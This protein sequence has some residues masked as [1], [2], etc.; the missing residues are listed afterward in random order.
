MTKRSLAVISLFLCG[1]PGSAAAA[2]LSTPPRVPAATPPPAAAPYYNWSGF[3]AG[4]NVG[5]GWSN[6]DF[7]NA[8]SAIGTPG[9][10][11]SASVA[12]VLGGGQIGYNYLVTPNFLLGVEADVSGAD[13]NGSV[14]SPS[15]A[16]QHSFN[17][18]LF[19]TA[20]GRLGF[21]WN[22]WLL[23]GTGGFAWGNEQMT[24][25]QIFGTAN[26]ATAGTAESVNQIGTGW[27]AGGGIE[28]GVARNWT[29]RA[30]YLFVDLGSSAF[31][32]PLSGRTTQFD[33]N[34][35]VVRFGVNYKF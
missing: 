4:L 12:G 27:T 31:S 5:G 14:T 2:D 19:G 15:G 21:A 6:Y 8:A 20:R 29:V 1:L 9:P 22:N 24:R 3:Y 28:W 35:N 17:T 11:H 32:F 33:N 16:V 34:F 13:L 10:A 30:E 23:Y 26:L 25:D 18:D 7:T